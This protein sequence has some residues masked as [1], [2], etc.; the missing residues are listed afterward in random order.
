MLNNRTTLSVKAIALLVCLAG[1]SV[2]VA[3][4]ACDAGF[5]Y[6]G[7]I[8]DHGW[9]YQHEIGRQAVEKEL[10]AETVYAESVPEGADAERAIRRM[11]ADNGCKA[12][13]TTSF[14]YM[15]PTLKVAKQFP[16]VKFEHATGFKRSDNVA[17]Y[18]ARFY[19]GRHVAGLIAGK[20]SKTGKIGYVASFPIPEVIRGIN[21]VIIAARSVNPDA[22]IQVVWVNSWFDPGKES[23]AAKVLIDQ[24][25]DFL[26]Q[27]TDSPAPVQTAE[28]RG[29]YAIGQASDMQRFAPKA[30]LT[31]I[32]DN[33]A[34]Y[35]VQ[36]VKEVQ[37]GKWQSGDVW[38]GFASGM[39]QMTP[40]NGVPADVVAIAEKA[41][42]GIISGSV[43][44]FAGPINGQD[45]KQ[46]VAAGETIDDGQLLGMNYYVEG[47][48]GSIP[49]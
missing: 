42:R 30:H 12:I 35:Y 17:T 48:I 44:P 16:D 4:A 24:G 9:T 5:I 32:V 21:A 39:V 18:S 38:G 3:N 46:I 37:D 29:I 33:W 26:F 22:T 47:V 28:T 13:F 49:Q 7:P 2:T 11:A 36:R 8:G 45:G 43:H 34:P 41:R 1:S 23:D 6:V 27:H 10:G 14:G 15:D 40:Y 31:A 25:V 19:E 20:M